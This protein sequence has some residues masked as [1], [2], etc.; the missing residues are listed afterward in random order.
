M[1][2][3]TELFCIGD[4][5]LKA[6][7]ASVSADVAGAAL[8]A[9]GGTKKEKEKG[10]R[11]KGLGGTGQD[12]LPALKGLTP[13][14]RVLHSPHSHPLRS[15]LYDLYFISF[16]SS[17]LFFFFEFNFSSPPFLQWLSKE[18]SIRF[19]VETLL[20]DPDPLVLSALFAELSSNS[21]RVHL[22][23]R[24]LFT[25]DTELIRA[26]YSSTRLFQLFCS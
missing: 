20:L 16:V 10:E 12:L 22:F 19:T 9:L 6:I 21:Q 3:F 24:R 18:E 1:F 11:T 13:F 14:H 4:S 7:N 26:T 15:Y 5:L 2:A 23:W 25:F 8:A 17:L